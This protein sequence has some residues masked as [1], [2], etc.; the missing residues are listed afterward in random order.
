[1]PQLLMS[2]TT[3]LLPLDGDFDAISNV[4]SQ[5]GFYPKLFKQLNLTIED[6]AS[7]FCRS[8]VNA[9]EPTGWIGMNVPKSPRRGSRG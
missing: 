7:V 9:L 8:F 3:V 5:D 2:C 6:R 1:M 4:P